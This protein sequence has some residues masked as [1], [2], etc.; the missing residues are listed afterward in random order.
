MIIG[1]IRNDDKIVIIKYRKRRPVN[2]IITENDQD[3]NEFEVLQN[4]VSVYEWTATGGQCK[5]YTSKDLLKDR[6]NLNEVEN[7]GEN[8]Q[9]IWETT[10]TANTTVVYI[11]EWNCKTAAQKSYGFHTN[12]THVWDRL[13]LRTIR[14]EL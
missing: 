2:H 3:I 11:Y 10:N 1:V 13:K 6:S 9:A 14:E 12:K 7:G 8:A 4:R 5:D